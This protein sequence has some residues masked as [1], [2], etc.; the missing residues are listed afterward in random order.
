MRKRVLDL[1]DEAKQMGVKTFLRGDGP[2][3]RIPMTITSQLDKQ[4]LIRNDLLTRLRLYSI[5]G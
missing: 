1:T 4:V 3:N 5:Q 2:K